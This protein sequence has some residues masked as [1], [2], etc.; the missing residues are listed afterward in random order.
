MLLLKVDSI[1]NTANHAH[2][3]KV[4]VPIKTNAPFDTYI[5]PATHNT[6][7]AAK[8]GNRDNHKEIR[9]VFWLVGA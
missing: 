5:H 9:Y 7:D 4:L 8:A 3:M 2:V 1:I 6:I